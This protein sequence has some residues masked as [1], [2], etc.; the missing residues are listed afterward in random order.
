MNASHPV[1]FEFH[2]KISILIPFL[3]GSYKA[4]EGSPPSLIKE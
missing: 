2:F 4:V 3:A 1:E